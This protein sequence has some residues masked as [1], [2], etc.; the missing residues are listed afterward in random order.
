MQRLA[1]LEIVFYE[2]VQKD[3]RVGKLPPSHACGE[4]VVGTHGD[5][6]F[7]ARIW[8]NRQCLAN[9]EHYEVDFVGLSFNKDKTL[10]QNKALVSVHSLIDNEM[11]KKR[12]FPAFWFRDRSFIPFGMFFHPNS[13]FLYVYGNQ[14]W[15]SVDGGNFFS[16]MIKLEKEMV[17]KA[18]MCVYTQAIV[19]VTNKGNI[20]YTKAGLQGYAKLTSL[21]LSIFSMY[22]D[23]LGILNS[24]SLNN[25]FEDKLAVSEMDV[26][27]LLKED[28][29]G[30]NGALSAQYITEEQMI[31]LNH[32]PLTT[33]AAVTKFSS[34]HVG[35][36]LVYRPG[37]SGIIRKVFHYKIPPEF[38]SGIRIDILDRF[39]VETKA[40][41]PSISNSLTILPPAT[42]TTKYKLQL[43]TAGTD[44]FVA[45]DVEKTVVIPGS[46]SIFITQVVDDLNALGDPTMP[47]QVLLNE[48]IPSGQWF[49]YDF[50]T[51]NGRKW[52]IIVDM[53]RYTIQQF[54]ELPLNAIAYLDLGSQVQFT[55]QVTPVNT[56]YQVFHLA[57]MKVIVGRPSLLE[58]NAEDYWDDNY[59]YIINISVQSKFFEQGKSTIAVIITYGSLL[60]DVTTI[61]LTLKNSCSYLKTMHYVLP[62]QISETDWLSEEPSVEHNAS[63]LSRVLKNLPVNYR[64][65]SELGIAVPLT[66]NFYNADPS[67]PRQRDYFEGS[68]ATGRYKQCANKST[69]A[70]CGCTTN[71]KLSFAVAFSDCR[72]KVLRM[73]FPVTKLPLYFT[74]KEEGRFQNL[75][76]PYFITITEVNNRTKWK[77]SG[78]NSTS[79]TL[80]MK[81]YLE[82][83]LKTQLYNPD[84]LTITI[85][86][87]ELFHFRVS[88]IPGVSFCNLFDEFQIYVD[89]SPLAFPGQ[90]LISTFTAVLIGGIIFVAFILHVYEIQIG[91][92][93]KGKLKRNKVASK[94][95]LST[96]SGVVFTSAN[97]GISLNMLVSLWLFSPLVS[98]D[99]YLLS[100]QYWRETH[101][102]LQHSPPAAFNFIPTITV[103]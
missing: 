42:G 24:I 98:L 59:S 15:L 94:V 16:P 23:H 41:S 86:G 46:S 20:F 78:I 17:V 64:P 38:V 85:T 77:V 48:S 69:R 92:I 13:H 40:N 34:L 65:P 67:K 4:A 8:Y 25:T 30:F 9:R 70:E 7:R 101:S 72:E 10:S 71:M 79:S 81:K 100:S 93:L 29:L 66:K 54:D 35:K 1:R 83:Q 50:G 31:L 73:K 103:L 45:S 18:D 47:N 12:K 19:F 63:F 68:K 3:L 96:G 90:Y 99:I 88:T 102:G 74:I 91:N 36:S 95:S 52:R 5:D 80:K 44:V 60:C 51:K 22:F 75:T 28:D 97:F 76:S 26:N 53:C 62:I 82:S 27:T 89:D 55:F 33:G 21:P 37:G 32:Q 11:N 87:S 61:V 56:A 58:V 6:Y 49:L 2:Q 14:V 57:L 84:G 39:P 43:T